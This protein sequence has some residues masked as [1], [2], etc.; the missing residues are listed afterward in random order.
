VIQFESLEDLQ[1]EL[2]TLQIERNDLQFRVNQL[3]YE[4]M[5]QK[6]TINKRNYWLREK[7]RDISEL[8][9]R[10]TCW[11]KWGHDL[12]GYE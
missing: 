12:A 5:R 7:S 10:L 4:N 3:E 9:G 11:K 1:E 8:K 2:L 6:E